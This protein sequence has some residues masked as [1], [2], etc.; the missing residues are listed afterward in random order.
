MTLDHPDLTAH[1]VSLGPLDLQD[2][3]VTVAEMVSLVLLVPLVLEGLMVPPVFLVF[4]DKKVTGASTASLAREEQ[5]ANLV[6]PVMPVHLV[7]PVLLDPKEPEAP[8]EKGVRMVQVAHRVSVV[9]MACLDPMDLQVQSALPDLRVFLVSKVPKE[10]QELLEQR[11]LLV[12]RDLVVRMD[13]RDNPESLVVKDLLVCPDLLVRRA[14][15]VT[16]ALLDRLD[17][18]DPVD[19]PDF[20][21]LLVH[22]VLRV[23]VVTL[24]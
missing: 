16:P 13:R 12:N 10:R 14:V 3:R 23:P 22:L 19:L 9:L 1:L 5:K 4:L 17:S 7:H 24:V 18:L 20:L 15:W 11:A 6:N 2:L 21:V 8:P